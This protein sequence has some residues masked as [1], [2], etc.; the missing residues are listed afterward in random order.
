MLS[1]MSIT[2]ST[3]PSGSVYILYI[4]STNVFL[5]SGAVNSSSFQQIICVTFCCFLQGQIKMPHRQ[6]SVS[7]TLITVVL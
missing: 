2:I 3:V 6:T 1:G 5:F 4:I 7:L